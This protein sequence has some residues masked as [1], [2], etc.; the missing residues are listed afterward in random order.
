VQ[1]AGVGTHADDVV[2]LQ[3]A[4]VRERQQGETRNTRFSMMLC[5]R[6]PPGQAEVVSLVHDSL[7]LRSGAKSTLASESE[8]GKE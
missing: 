6:R 8:V 4:A 1:H 5:D 7:I 2:T 3:A